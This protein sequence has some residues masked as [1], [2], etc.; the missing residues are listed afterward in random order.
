MATLIATFLRIPGL[1]GA[2][3]IKDLQKNRDT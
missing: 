2:L 3:G 1:D